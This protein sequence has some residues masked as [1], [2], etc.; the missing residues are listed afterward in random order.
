ME[1]DEAEESARSKEKN[2]I[3]RKIKSSFAEE[4]APPSTT[5]DFYK[6]G[7]VLGKGAFGKVNLAMHKLVRKLVAIKSVN[8]EFLTEEVSKKKFTQE[9]RIFLR[10]RHPHVV[11]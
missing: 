8:K 7:K 5:V 1:V 10:T 3:V 4:S 2:I 6:I 11:K 9:V